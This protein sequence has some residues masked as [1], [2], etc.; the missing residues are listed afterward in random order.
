LGPLQYS[1]CCSSSQGTEPP[2]SRFRRRRCLL[3][4]CEQ[5]FWPSRPQCRFCSEGC[6]RQAKKWWSWRAAAKWRVTPEGME[7]RQAQ[8]RRY[9]RRIPLPLIEAPTTVTEA[10]PIESLVVAAGPAVSSASAAEAREGQRPATILEDF[11]VHDC[12]RPG[13]YE[14]FAVPSP[15]S[16]KRFCSVAC[17]KAL[18]RVLAREA[19]YRKRRRAG[20][21]PRCRRLRAKPTPRKRC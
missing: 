6:R 17:R 19:A 21:W 7:C 1:D 11:W 16:L 2:R 18:R 3:K 4:G 15:C 5:F 12:R 14:T 20:I 8:S 13:C 10:S 9:R